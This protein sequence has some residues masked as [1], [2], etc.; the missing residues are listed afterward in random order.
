[1]TLPRYNYLNSTSLAL[2][3]TTLP[4]RERFVDDRIRS[5]TRANQNSPIQKN[6]LFGST[7]SERK[8]ESFLA[9]DF[10]PCQLDW[11]GYESHY[12][13][14][15]PLVCGTKCRLFSNLVPL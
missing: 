7:I 5:V 9:A 3:V 13:S 2:V 1:M 12:L 15:I 4:V 14:V 10:I 8:R 6:Q 11:R